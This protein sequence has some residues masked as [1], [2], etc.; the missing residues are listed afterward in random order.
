MIFQGYFYAGAG[1]GS[2]TLSS[3]GVDDQAL[4]WIG[5]KAYGAGW[6]YNN[7]DYV[8]T[9]LPTTGASTSF[10]LAAGEAVPI[11]LYYGN[12]GGPGRAVFTVYGPDGARY[13]DTTQFFVG[14]CATA[15]L[16]QP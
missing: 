12:G 11:N 5:T 1:A 7:A 3:V 6:N 16:F 2:Y 8:G 14:A 4:A 13:D 10:T 15:G 9:D